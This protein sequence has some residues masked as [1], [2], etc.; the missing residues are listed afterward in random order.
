MDYL[1]CEYPHWDYGLFADVRLTFG[2]LDDFI[3][4]SL[5]CPNNSTAS[6]FGG[7]IQ[8]KRPKLSRLNIAMYWLGFRI[9]S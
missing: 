5:G 7:G 6:N 4:K 9:L 3:I 1:L 2:H 8:S